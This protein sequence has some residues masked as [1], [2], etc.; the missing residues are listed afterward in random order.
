MNNGFPKAKTTNFTGNNGLNLVSTIVNNDLEWVCRVNNKEYDYGIDAYLDIVTDE[1][2][3]TGQTIAVQVKSGKS[4]FKNKTSNGFTFY[5]EMKHLN[6]Y[7]NSQVPIVIIIC[8]IKK[9]VCYWQHFKKDRIENTINSWKM[10]I[11]KNNKFSISNK[12]KLLA[13]LPKVKNHTDDLTRLWEENLLLKKSDLLLYSIDRKHIEKYNIKPLKRFFKRLQVNDSLYISMQNKIE[14][15]TFG[16]EDDKREVYEI[17]EVKKYFKKVD[18]K[19]KNWL[20]FVNK[21]PPA[22]SLLLFIFCLSNAEV[23]YNNQRLTKKE[24]LSYLSSDQELPEM[25]IKIDKKIVSSL[26][27]K[28]FLRVFDV[29]NKLGIPSTPITDSVISTL[30]AL[31]RS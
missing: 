8:D 22:D 27:K 31:E 26:L 1:G 14:I 9:R 11:P 5:G 25:H 18:K 29:T 17:K 16:Y 23:L 13:L 24:I 12:N 4:Y 10:N 15:S 20:Y 3:V 30:K 2:F 28:N 7:I 21:T 6:Y 19:I